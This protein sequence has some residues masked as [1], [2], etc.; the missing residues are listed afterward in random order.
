MSYFEFPHTRNYDGD[1][2]YII[3]KIQE[4]SDEYKNFAD[5]NT[6]KFADPVEWN[7]TSNYV[8]NIIVYDGATS[9]FYIS[10]KPVPSGIAVTNND[11]WML[12]LPFKVEDGLNINSVNP[13]T[14]RTITAKINSIDNDISNV[15][16]E[17]TTQGEQLSEI[18]SDVT[19]IN[20]TLNNEISER[21]SADVL[22]NARI[23]EITNLPEGSTSGDAELAD[24]RV[25]DSGLTYANAGNAVRGQIGDGKYNFTES[26][27]YL[28]DITPISFQN[29]GY[30]RYTTNEPYSVSL[31]PSL[32]EGR[33][34]AL[35]PVSAGDTVLVNIVGG[36]AVAR[37][38]GF[39]DS[40][41]DL[42]SQSALNV[43]LN[44]VILT[45][46]EN[47]ATLVLNTSTTG[48]YYAY[49]APKELLYK[50]RLTHVEHQTKYINNALI[51]GHI[52]IDSPFIRGSHTN[53]NQGE[54]ISNTS[55]RVTTL[56]KVSVE[57][58]TRFY[59]APGFRVRR[60]W[61]INGVFDT[62]DGS[63]LERSAILYAGREY[64]INIARTVEDTS[65]VAN[66]DEFVSKFYK[67][68][69]PVTNLNVL[70][71]GDSLA[72]GSR[73]DGK[74]FIG[75]I[76]CTYAN[77]GIGG[78]T[79][80]NDVNSSGS[81][82]TEHYM[83]AENIPDTIVKYADQTEQDWYITPDVIIACG[84]VN[85]Y[86]RSVT[87]GSIP[88]SPVTNDS[89]ASELDQSTVLGGLQYLFY[90]MIKLYPNAHRMFV[91][92]HKTR[93]WAW[94]NN[95]AGYTQT[96]L[97][98]NIATVCRLYNVEI[99]DVFNESIASSCFDQ[100]VSPTPY[101]DDHSITHLYYIDHDKIHPLSL[102]YKRAYEPLVRSALNKVINLL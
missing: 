22:I 61:F 2:G 42:I 53:G 70:I 52:T 47:S 37:A 60:Y 46:P 101:S 49:K 41:G 39:C 83:E 86:N 102:G 79:L 92:T 25:S 87:M 89:E 6:I 66:I 48:E 19:N 94:T 63:W 54:A 5:Y 31:T 91:I 35:I 76:G 97:H 27:K 65:E 15:Q 44:D 56:K 36:G 95:N 21:T 67:F 34:C 43:T 9:G 73:N 29:N 16:N 18:D 30:Y 80:S 99:I 64:Y 57:K 8:A 77:I 81:T 50:N 14:N 88:T 13:V 84:G 45:A 40:N 68:P 72:R 20:N 7:I 55:Y 59:I 90:Q 82:D 11:Y 1:L 23:D 26:I 38:W 75:D 71:T 93:N 51:Y 78:A 32:Y 28:S 100:Y 3:K 12:V 10:K 4:L 74:G 96:I 58:T 98:D 33:A 17:V 62:F 85:D 24:I 69:D